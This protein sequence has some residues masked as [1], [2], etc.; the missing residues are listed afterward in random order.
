LPGLSDGKVQLAGALR[1]P[2]VLVRFSTGSLRS[3]HSASEARVMPQKT[4][5]DTEARPNENATRSGSAKPHRSHRGWIIAGVVVV[6]VLLV[7]RFAGSPVAEWALNRKLASLP[8]YTGHA[9]G[10]K[11]ALWRGTVDVTNL[12][13]F[14]RGHEKE[15]PVMRIKKAAMSVSPATLL[16]GK[17]GGAATIDGAE[18]TVVTREEDKNKPKEPLD[19]K[20]KKVERWQDT[21]R[22]AMPME[23]TRLEVKNS[24]FRYLDRTK[25]PNVDVGIENLRSLAVDLQNRPK[26]NGDPLPAKVEVNGVVTGN[27]QL[28]A[29]VQLD[30]LGQPPHFAANFEIRQLQL[31]AFN[32]FLLAYANADVSKGSFEM[33]SEINADKGAYNGYVKP[34]F[35]DLDFRTASD[36]DKNAV[37]LLTKKVVAGVASILKNDDRDQ[38][39]TK[40]PFAGNFADNKVDIWTTIVNLFRNAFVQAIRGGLEGQ[41]PRR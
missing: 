24:R 26:A 29:S 35:K 31:P 12:V 37:Q 7:I 6:V 23:L 4:N 9:E 13:L 32:S 14:E 25:Q 17:L 8:G 2:D 34:L 39:A 15:E 3:W 27:G 22:E 19:E 16:S 28:H 11:L 20:V 1:T 30:P 33:Y 36:K 40:A 21:F 18:V 5:R 38:V 10:V 41:T